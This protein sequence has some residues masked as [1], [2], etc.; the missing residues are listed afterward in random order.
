MDRVQIIERTLRCYRAG[1]WSLL[2]VI[3]LAPA[4]VAFYDFARVRAATRNDWNPAGTQLRVG[5]A[6]ATIGASLSLLL[7]SIPA[8]VSVF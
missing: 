7:L 5:F 6:L 1:W 2:P 4:M 8:W 3:G